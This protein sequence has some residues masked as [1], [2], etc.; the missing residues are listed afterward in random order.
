MRFTRFDL[1]VFFTQQSVQKD[2]E[3]VM[4]PHPGMHNNIAAHCLTAQYLQNNIS[5]FNIEIIL[6]LQCDFI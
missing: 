3:N 5:S 1:S 2:I 4:F 6:W